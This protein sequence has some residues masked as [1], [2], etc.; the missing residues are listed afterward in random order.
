MKK[1][2][3]LDCDDPLVSLRVF[4]WRNANLDIAIEPVQKCKQP[5]QAETVEI[6]VLQARHVRLIHAEEFAGLRL[7]Q[8]PSRENAVDRNGEIGFQ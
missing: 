6:P 2:A 8:F 3:P 1:S 7:R 5:F 4:G